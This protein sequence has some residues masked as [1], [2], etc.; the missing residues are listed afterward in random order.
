MADSKEDN[1]SGKDDHY[2]KVLEKIDLE[3]LMNKENKSE[4]C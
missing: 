3:S 4:K 1:S 2:Q